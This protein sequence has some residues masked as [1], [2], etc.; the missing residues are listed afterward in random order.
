MLVQELAD[1]VE[2]FKMIDRTRRFVEGCSH[3]GSFMSEVVVK[4]VRDVIYGIDCR[5]VLAHECEI[6]IK[7]VFK[8]YVVFV[9]DSLL[10]DFV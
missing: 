5:H 7:D 4:S 8:V 9:Y 1:I 6:L 10:E 2:T 3:C